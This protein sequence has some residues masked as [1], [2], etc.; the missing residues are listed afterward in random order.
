MNIKAIKVGVY[1]T[2][3][4]N[5]EKWVSFADTFY[6]GANIRKAIR[7]L[8]E[9]GNVIIAGPKGYMLTDNVELASKYIKSR[10]NELTKEMKPLKAMS[11]TLGTQDLLKIGE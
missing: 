10:W 8:R 9:N 11:L 1:E 3:T 6:G 4:F 5:K 2:L 7:E